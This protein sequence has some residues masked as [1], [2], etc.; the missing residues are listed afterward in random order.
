M[1]KNNDYTWV[2][3][4]GL[5]VLILYGGNHGWFSS[6]SYNDFPTPTNL[7][8]QD[9]SYWVKLN[10]IPPVICAEDLIEGRIESNMYNDYC[11]IFVSVNGGEWTNLLDVRLDNKGYFSQ[12]ERIM[13]PGTAEFV[14]LCCDDKM[15]CKLSNRYSLISNDCSSSDDS[16][17]SS[18]DD[19]DDSDSGIYTCGQG[20]DQYSCGGTCPVNYACYELWGDFYSWCACAT[21]PLE[22]GGTGEIHPDWKPD[23]QYFNPIEYGE[24]YEP[25]C[26]DDDQC[27]AGFCKDGTCHKYAICEDMDGRDFFTSSYIIVTGEDGVTKTYYDECNGDYLHERLCTIQGDAPTG[28]HPDCTS[29]GMTWGCYNGRCMEII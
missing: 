23:G 20:V 18:S 27:S 14:A 16:D 6:Y 19:S 4:I 12:T 10:I 25:E 28:F 7:I 9:S 8:E 29:Y 21:G 2:W 24:P 26:T 1:K 11:R 22:E 3:I 17:D 15:V 13:Y 5:A